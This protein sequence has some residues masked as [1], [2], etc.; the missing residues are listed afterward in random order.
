M[1]NDSTPEVTTEPTAP[2][3]DSPETTVETTPTAD[4]SQS[5]VPT[6][7]A[8]AATDAPEVSE[9]A[10]AIAE[11]AEKR[12]TPIDPTDTN[13]VNL[14][15]S[16]RENQQ[17]FHEANQKS[18]NELID[19]NASDDYQQLQA[20][21]KV[22][23]YFNDNPDAQQYK[24]K[25]TQI[26]NEKAASNPDA[27]MTY[28]NDLDSLYKLARFDEI[29]TSEQRAAEAARQEERERLARESQT[30]TSRPVATT[31]SQEGDISITRAEFER[32]T[33]E[34]YQQIRDKNYTI[35]D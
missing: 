1:D 30:T 32:M 17:K 19:E 21:M 6:T 9:E 23:E 22:M 33:P 3:Q 4:D 31:A 7:D 18:A 12:G 29:S 24:D 26:L 11:W 13:Q 35:V 28:A 14:A 10:Q 8:P 25:M 5:T 27:V 34:Q 15:K 2:T 20:K 16:A